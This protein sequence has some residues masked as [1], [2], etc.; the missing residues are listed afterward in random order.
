[1]QGIETYSANDVR[2]T[3][4]GVMVS[5]E[6]GIQP[7][8][9]AGR[10]LEAQFTTD[11][12]DIVFLTHGI[13]NEE[14]LS[15]SLLSEGIAVDYLSMGW[16][17]TQAVL[18][19]VESVEGKVTFCFPASK[20]WRLSV[21]RNLEWRRPMWFTGVSRKHRFQSYFNLEKVGE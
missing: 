14:Q 12:G 3:P 11:I 8:E 15:I 7:V 4:E 1:M 20:S 19:N 10:Y 9:V 16:P 21:S 13:L 18:E 6:G 2:E 5:L 17:F